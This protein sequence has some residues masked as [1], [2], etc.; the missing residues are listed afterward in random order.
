MRLWSEKEI[1]TYTKR[2]T[3]FVD[4]GLDAGEAEELAEQMLD[5]DFFGEKLDD[6]R[7]CF[8]CK[9]LTEDLKCPELFDHKKKPQPAP[10]FLLRRCDHFNLRGKK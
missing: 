5:R 6:R 7:V 8:E 3:K 2:V 4:R 10:V 9:K 1:V